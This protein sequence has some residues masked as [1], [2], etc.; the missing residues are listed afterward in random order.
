MKKLLLAL[1]IIFSANAMAEIGNRTASMDYDCKISN[2]NGRVLHNQ[3]GTVS[4]SEDQVLGNYSCLISR[5]YQ[6]VCMQFRRWLQMDNIMFSSFYFKH[7]NSRSD[8]KRT[9]SITNARFAEGAV[10]SH[11]IKA[12]FPKVRKGNFE[13]VFTNVIN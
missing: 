8:I 11:K 7:M 5:D 6:I 10:Y 1:I 2:H 12:R 9:I 4:I 3:K 13:C